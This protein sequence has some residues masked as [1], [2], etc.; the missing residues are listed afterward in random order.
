D[1]CMRLHPYSGSSTILPSLVSRNVFVTLASDGNGEEYRLHPLFRDFLRRRLLSEVGRSGVMA[2][3]SRIAN[4]F[5]NS[6]NWERAMRHFL[7][8]EEFDRAVKVIAD[9]GQEWIASGSLGSLAALADALPAEAMER[10]PRALTYRAEVA[11]LRGELDK[12][13]SMLRRAA[14]LLQERGDGEG[15]SEALHSL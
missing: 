13:Q 1:T 8:A 12:A 5:L 7:E 9:K 10:H 3:H 6:G 2:E 14:I 4:F 15:E 11:R